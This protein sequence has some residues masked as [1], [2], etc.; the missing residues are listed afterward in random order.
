MMAMDY[1]N[2]NPES[3]TSPFLD[4]P[5]NDKMQWYA[6]SAYK[7][8]ILDGNYAY[9]DTVLT[10]E[11]FVN[12]ILK[13]AKPTENPGQI[14]IFADVDTMNPNFQNIQTYA[15]MIRA[16]WG[17]FYPKNILTRAVAVQMLQI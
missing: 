13:V 12:L 6:I 2:I 17:K 7:L 4:I 1:Y 8:W 5:I 3:G 15:F 16:K 14:R 10:K 11:D 9:P